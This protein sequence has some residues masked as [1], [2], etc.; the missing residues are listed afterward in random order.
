MSFVYSPSS[1]GGGASVGGGNNI[2]SNPQDFTATANA[3]GKTIT[4]SL[5]TSSVL[6]SVLTTAHF[7]NAVIKKVTTGGVVSS[8]PTTSVAYV[9]ATGVLTLADMTENFAAGDTVIVMIPGP[10][11]SYDETYDFNKTGDQFAPQ[12]EDNTLGVAYG[13]RRP[14]PSATSADSSDVSAALE[15]S[16]VTKATPGRVYSV[17]F[18]NGNAAARWFQLFNSAT[19][20]ADTTVPILSVYVGI[21]QSVHL[22]WENGLYCSS[23]ISWCNSSTGGAKTVGA[24]DSLAN[25]LYS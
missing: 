15:A 22:A 20:P 18:Y 25:I 17:D 5:F 3:G 7:S 2:W 11:K 19:V 13:M 23:G 1:G 8:I 21:G 14:V 12:Y 6:S 16:S 10:D 4:L 9:S 24:A